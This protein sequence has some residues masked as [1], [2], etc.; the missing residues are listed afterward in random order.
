[1]GGGIGSLITHQVDEDSG[2]GATSTTTT[3]PSTAPTSEF[4]IGK[5][6]ALR[7]HTYVG[8]CS[9]TTVPIDVGRYCSSLKH[10]DHVIRVYLVGPVASEGDLYV[11]ARSTAGWQVVF[12]AVTPPLGPTSPR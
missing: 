8:D 12:V 11:L 2:T 1:V 3:S 9:N 4:A 5:Y 10:D 7:G 6:L